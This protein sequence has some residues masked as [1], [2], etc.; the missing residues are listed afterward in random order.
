MASS[1][2][3][4]VAPGKLLNPQSQFPLEMMIIAFTAVWNFCN[5]KT[6]KPTPPAKHLG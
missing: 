6:N 4:L 1:F 5:D 2:T 3:G